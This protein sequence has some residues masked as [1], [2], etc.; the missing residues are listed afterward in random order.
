[1]TRGGTCW[2]WLCWTAASRKASRHPTESLRLRV[3][4]Q[5]RCSCRW[6]C[7]GR[8]HLKRHA[9]PVGRGRHVCVLRRVLCP[10]IINM[11]CSASL[12]TSLPSKVCRVAEA[13]EAHNQ[14]VRRL[15]RVR[16]DAGSRRHRRRRQPCRAVLVTDGPPPSSSS[17]SSTS[18]HAVQC[19]SL[20]VHRRR[21]RRAEPC[22]AHART[23]AC[24]HACSCVGSSW[25]GRRG[26]APQS[27]W[28]PSPCRVAFVVV[29]NVVDVVPCRAVRVTDDRCHRRRGA[30]P[31]RARTDG[32]P[33]SSS[34]S[35][36]DRAVLMH[37][38]ALQRGQYWAR[39]AVA[40]AVVVALRVA[41]PSP[42]SRLS[43][44]STLSLSRSASQFSNTKLSPTWQKQQ[45][46]PALVLDA[47]E[48]D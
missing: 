23:R 21:R 15:I 16:A 45:T 4:P 5:R 3:T 36:S 10:E 44:S 9:E 22:C 39:T 41:S 20:M 35:S 25:L 13:I 19:V 27:S 30:V 12:Q 1:M 17:S 32:P 24:T 14:Q 18:C 26:T 42:S 48:D 7:R 29:V 33:A 6:S 37:A 47:H 38:R 46:T 31:C 34:S 8:R 43:A 11:L 40:F 28:S 2:P